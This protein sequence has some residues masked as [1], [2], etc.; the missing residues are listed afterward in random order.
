MGSLLIPALAI[1]F[2][3]VTEWHGTISTDV[4]RVTTA[5]TART[6]VESL[7]AFRTIHGKVPSAE[8]G[9]A[10]LVPEFL[11]SPSRDAWG[12]PFVYAP[13]AD[14]RWADIISYG[15]DGEPGGVGNAADISGRFGSPTL[16]SPLVFDILARCAFFIL[17]I[18]GLLG[19]GRSPWA[20]GMLAGMAALLSI[21]LLSTVAHLFDLS[22]LGIL[23]AILTLACMTGG[24]AVWRGTLGAPA[25]ASAALVC[26]YLLLGTLIGD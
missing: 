12:N 6:I 14:T 3:R 11:N 16:H 23:T 19:A 13:S 7:E 22:L 15:A 1:S 18:I 2:A 17:L 21:A 26:G 9:L 8:D 25:L 10:P 20:A 24:I 5:E 4:R